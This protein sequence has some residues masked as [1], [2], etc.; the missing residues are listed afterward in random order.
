MSFFAVGRIGLR[1]GL[2]FVL[3]VSF[4]LVSCSRQSAPQAPNAATLL[5]RIAAAD[6]AKYPSLQET[7]HWSNPYLVIRPESVG[8]LSS[9]AANE[10]QV[11]KPGEVLNVLARLP[12]SA[13][14]YGRAVAILVEEKASAS[15]AD[16]IAIRRSRGI[17]AGDLESAHVAIQWIPASS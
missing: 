14:P 4:S 10:E 6:P 16:K 17:V 15:E 1:T 12:G 2:I 9:V 3:V 5:Q 7:R 11:L 8:L 13:W